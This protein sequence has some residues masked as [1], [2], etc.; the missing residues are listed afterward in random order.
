MII[1]VSNSGD[2]WRLF[3]NVDNVKHREVD[4]EEAKTI[5]ERIHEWA[6]AIGEVAY[7]C[8]LRERPN[9]TKEMKFIEIVTTQK[10]EK[11]YILANPPV[12]FLNDDGKTIE[13]V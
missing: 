3:D 9:V 1:K 5:A 11:I 12:Y 2:G 8:C 7:N 13:R 10:K 4:L 6:F